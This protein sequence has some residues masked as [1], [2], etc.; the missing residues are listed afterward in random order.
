MN[1]IEIRKMT[2]R[3]ERRAFLT[4]PWEVYK[5]DPL[6]VP[7]LIPE[8]MKVIDPQ[9]GAFFNRGEAEFFAAY[10]GGKMVGTICAAE[11]MFTNQQRGR[12][13]CVIG[14][15]EFIPDYT[16]FQALIEYVKAWAMARGLDTL[17]GPFHLDY[18]DAYGLLVSGRD[19]PP[20]LMCAHT[21][22]YYV[23]YF[24]RAGFEPARAANL[25]FA[26][27]L[28]ESPEQERL[29]K[30]ADHL[31]KKGR[32]TIRTANWDDFQAE[33][34]RVHKLLNEA[35][36]WEDGGIPWHRDQ[37]EA[38]VAPFKAIAD[39]DL[40]LFAD[41]DGET[42]GWFPGVPN[43]NEIFIQVNGL[44]YPWNYLQ[45]LWKMKKTPK[46]LTVK[47]VLVLPEYQKTGVAVLLF[48]EMARRGRE[49]GYQWADLS[50]TSEDNPD[51]PQLANRLGAVEYKRWQ[52]YHKPV[53]S[54][55]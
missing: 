7:P 35:L 55:S 4:F 37:L 44:R 40:I 3:R 10:R 8:R 13:D 1:G 45:L 20:A 36:A 41:V 9:K 30:L 32:I 52:V 34:D 43:L 26:I 54:K 14:F 28:R 23:T 17:L 47:S 31:R 12:H 2:T 21:P 19:R 53:P 6:W 33:V 51:T 11:D 46:S 5:N 39:P 25:A 27:D 42:V 38:M 48:D 29:T 50:I 16:V 24:E 22:E 18:E 15:V 49:K